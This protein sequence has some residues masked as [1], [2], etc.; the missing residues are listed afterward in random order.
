M[1]IDTQGAHRFADEGRCVWHGANELD[2]FAKRL[3]DGSNG[4]ACSDGDDDAAALH[5]RGNLRNHL[6][7]FVRLDGEKQNIAALGDRLIGECRLDGKPA[8]NGVECLLGVCTG[9]Y[10]PCGYQGGV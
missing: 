4:L 1:C 2:L 8:V 7:K 5:M 10:L 9:D 6:I 3:F